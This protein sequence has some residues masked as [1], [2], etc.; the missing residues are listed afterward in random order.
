M[1]DCSVYILQDIYDSIEFSATTRNDVEVVNKMSEKLNLKLKKAT[2]II[3]DVCEFVVAEAP[4]ITRNSCN[5]FNTFLTPCPVLTSAA[6]AAA[7]AIPPFQRPPNTIVKANF[8]GV[9]GTGTGSFAFSSTGSGDIFG[10]GAATVNDVNIGTIFDSNHA[11]LTLPSAVGS[12]AGPA[13]TVGKSGSNFFTYMNIT[14]SSGALNGYSIDEFDEENHLNRRLQH[15]ASARIAVET[16][17]GLNVKQH[18]FVSKFDRS[19]DN[20]CQYFDATHLR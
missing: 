4:K 5:K 15:Y 13:N 9:S 2:N 17:K 16:D 1:H 3:N 12:V 10:A 18:Y 6:A 19:T 8:V 11:A 7:A 20:K 14:P